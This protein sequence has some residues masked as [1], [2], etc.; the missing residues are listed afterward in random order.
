M[1]ILITGATGFVGHH[2][3]RSLL[4]EGV[5][6]TALARN[7]DAVRRSP[8]GFSQVWRWDD[9]TAPPAECYA[10]V[11]SIIHLAG[12]PIAKGRWTEDRKKR[13]WES[14][15]QSTENLLAGLKSSRSPVRSMISASAIGIYGDRGDEVLTEASAAG[16]GFLADLCAA[17]EQA[18]HT[19]PGDLRVVNLRTGIVLGAGGF[20]EQVLPVFKVGAGGKLGDGRQWMSWIHLE[21]LLALIKFSMSST[22]CVG[23]INAVAPNPVRNRD[24]TRALGR[25]L[26]RPTFLPAPA[27]AIKAAFGQLSEVLLG[28]QRVSCEKALKLGFKFKY[29][30]LEGALADVIR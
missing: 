23:A 1:K 17:W 3:A 5:D 28:S 24:M 30:D 4:N 2:L 21:D 27:F 8:S 9:S 18:S 12:E 11:T 15:V 20:L 7:P 22:E 16:D 29:N 13:L 25:A 6:V 14:R 26:H 19:G 10:N